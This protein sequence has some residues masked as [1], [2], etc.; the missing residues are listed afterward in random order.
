M[1]YDALIDSARS[2]Q[3]TVDLLEMAKLAHVHFLSLLLKKGHIKALSC[4][5]AAFLLTGSPISSRVHN[6]TINCIF[7]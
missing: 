5:A 3:L 2:F 4:V 6:R 1:L 7:G